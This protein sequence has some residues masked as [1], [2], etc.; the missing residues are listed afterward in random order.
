MKHQTESRALVFMLFDAF[1]AAVGI[2]HHAL[3]GIF[4]TGL[5]LLLVHSLNITLQELPTMTVARHQFLV[6]AHEHL[7]RFLEVARLAAEG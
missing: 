2:L 7:L 6:L 1:G 4:R 3:V 5:Y